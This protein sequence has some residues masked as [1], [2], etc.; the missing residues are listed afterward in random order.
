MKE[1]FKLGL[2]AAVIGAV[3]L[4]IGTMLGADLSSVGLAAASGV[5]L[6]L[7]RIGTPLERLVGFLFGT[8]L[9][10]F[11]IAMQTGVL[12]G[13][14]SSVGNALS[15]G[16]IIIAISVVMAATRR[17]IPAWSMLLGVFT[18]ATAMLTI[19]E[20]EPWTANQWI[21]IYVVSVL[22]A[23]MV[24]FLTVIP[25]ELW[26]KK[27]GTT[28][29]THSPAELPAPTTPTPVAVGAADQGASTPAPTDQAP[30]AGINIL[31][32]DQK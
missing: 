11:Y 28:G 18:Y 22:G 8:A 9:G 21:S 32:G 13:G 20:T 27:K 30:S 6:A 26:T 4:F 10:V 25:V 7:V 29:P 3:G 14:F 24:G 31:G 12:P 19:V 1:T 16:V 17:K 23:A 15:L 2:S 5:I